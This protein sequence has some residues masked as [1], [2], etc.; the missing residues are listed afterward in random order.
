MVQKGKAENPQR[1]PLG[2]PDS[3]VALCLKDAG[4]GGLFK[5]PRSRYPA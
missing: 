3:E 2:C 1:A 4:W 5:V